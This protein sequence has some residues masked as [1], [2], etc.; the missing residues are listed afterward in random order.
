MSVRSAIGLI[1]F[2]TFVGAGAI[3]ESQGQRANPASTEVS[4]QDLQRAIQESASEDRVTR[5]RA[6]RA[7]RATS[8]ASSRESVGAIARLLAAEPA[9]PAVR[10]ENWYE[11]ARALG[12]LAGYQEIPAS[13]VERLGQLSKQKPT[14]MYVN[15]GFRPPREAPRFPFH[16][17]AAEA[18]ESVRYADAKRGLAREVS[19]LSEPERIQRL[20]ALAWGALP[21]AEKNRRLAARELLLDAGTA[22]IPAALAAAPGASEEAQLALVDY[23]AKVCRESTDTR[24]VSALMTLA[25]SG[26][27]AVSAAALLRTGDLV[28]PGAAEA[29]VAQ[30]K[31]RGLRADVRTQ[32]SLETLGRLN[33]SAAAPF[34]AE[35]LGSEQLEIGLTAGR[36]LAR[37]GNEGMQILVQSSRSPEPNRRKASLHVLKR[38]REDP[39]ASRALHEALRAHPEDAAEVL[40]EELS[41]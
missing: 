20:S 30:L 16:V 35:Q 28:L 21:D 31:A 11:A 3:A 24:C 34:L 27:D 23:F 40:D 33:D 19:Q 36:A 17:E 22:G 5:I 32:L 26:H 39:R 12:T 25:D 4:A 2:L 41:P 14:V 13:V 9:D 37:L 18:V 1:S 38:H 15:T 10:E 6:I 29:L 8:R 7:I